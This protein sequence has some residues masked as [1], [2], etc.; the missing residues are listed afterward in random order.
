[1]RSTGSE[2]EKQ[3]IYEAYHQGQ[4]SLEHI[5]NAVPCA[6][7]LEDEGR[8]ITVIEDAIKAGELERLGGWT[9]SVSDTKARTKMR[10][11]ARKEAMEAEAHAKELGVWEELFGDGKKRP[12]RSSKADA[13]K[14]EDEED[15][16]DEP[17]VKSKRARST[18]STSKKAASAKGKSKGKKEAQG[19]N[20]DDQED[21]GGLAALI[22]KRQESRSGIGGLIARLEE[23]ANA[24]AD[25]R[26]S[27]RGGKGKRE[28]RDP[29]GGERLDPGE[30]NEE[31]FLAAQQRLTDTAGST[32]GK[33]T[34]KTKGKK[35][36]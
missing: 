26:Y 10:N 13:A 14:E 18:D 7:V 23:Q 20:E 4:G 25:A 17:P 24:E 34:T 9:S 11:N 31:E 22:Q 19:A 12:R 30:P 6:Q 16:E 35:G 32:K 2:E 1:M 29:L 28:C 8:F 36:R 3:D 33:G 5:L 15:E 27:A 21:L